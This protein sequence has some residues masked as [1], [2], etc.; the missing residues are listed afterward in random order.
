MNVLEA[1]L[2]ILACAWVALAWF[3]T[4]IIAVCVIPIIWLCCKARRA[5]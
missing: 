1:V 2:K 3:F 5:R 4:L